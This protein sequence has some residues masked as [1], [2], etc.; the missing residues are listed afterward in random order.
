MIIGITGLAGH[1]KDTI[2]N[3]LVEQHGYT[4]AAFADKVREAALAINPHVRHGSVARRLADLVFVE[5]WDNAK[6]SSDVRQLLQRIGTDM[7][8]NLLGADVWINA[9]FRTLDDSKNYVITDVRFPN[10]VDAIRQR[11]GEIWRVHRPNYDNGVGSDH[12][13][14]QF[15][16]K[17]KADVVVINDGTFNELTWNVAEWMPTNTDQRAEES[18]GDAP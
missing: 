14:E 2:G 9:L 17:I 6:Q 5:G 1:G 4:R 8:R 10:E 16:E 3:I 11:G 13:S 7:G 18:G 15:V 12:E